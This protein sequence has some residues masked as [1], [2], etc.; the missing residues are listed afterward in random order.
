M[1]TN[2]ILTRENESTNEITGSVVKFYKGMK[3]EYPEVYYLDYEVDEDTGI[4]N[5]EKK[6]K[7]YTKSQIKRNMRA[8]KNVFY[9]AKGAAA[10]NEIISFR[11]Q[12]RIPASTFSI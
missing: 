9:I 11:K 4:I 7:Y 1:K 12:Y 6:V 8:L 5:R 3:L 10:P 2:K